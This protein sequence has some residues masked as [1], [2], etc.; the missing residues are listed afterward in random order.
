MISFTSKGDFSKTYKF[1]K[2]NQYIRKYLIRKLEK[3]A[4]QGV[5]ALRINTPKDTGK[6][7]NSWYYEIVDDGETLTIYWKNSNLGAGWAPIALL[8]Q[9][10]HATGTGGYVQG[11]DYINPAMRPIFEKIAKNAWEE[12]T[13]D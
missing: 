7:A 3:Y 9:L 1:L 12:V 13:S 8:I 2:K 11:I 4:E 10:G 5:E 6:T